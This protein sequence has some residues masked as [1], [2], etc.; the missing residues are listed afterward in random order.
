MTDSLITAAEV[1]KILNL[2]TET[3]YRLVAQ[4]GLPASKIGGQWRFQTSRVLAW[5]DE[6]V[7]ES[8]SMCKAENGSGAKTRGK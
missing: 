3:V 2:N 6:Q 5:V 1:A 8:S 7:P 4:E